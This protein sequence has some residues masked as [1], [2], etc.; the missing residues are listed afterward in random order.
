MLNSDEEERKEST[1]PLQLVGISALNFALT[2]AEFSLHF[3][4]PTIFTYLVG[5]TKATL[6]LSIFS[7]LSFIAAAIALISG[8]LSDRNLFAKKKTILTKYG[9]RAPYFIFGTSLFS[10][11]LI[12]ISLSYLSFEIIFPKDEYY[13]YNDDMNNKAATMAEF[14]AILIGIFTIIARTGIGLTTA[15]YLAYISDTV[16]REQLGF[17]FGIILFV[18]FIGRLVAETFSFFFLHRFYVYFIFPLF[19]GLLLIVGLILTL[20]SSPKVEQKSNFNCNF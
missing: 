10:I 14:F 1:K 20:L 5:E 17:S 19:S 9:I 2:Y 3:Y 11:S 8:Y 16:K 4:L 7:I 6:Y 18:Y 13:S 15:T 12:L